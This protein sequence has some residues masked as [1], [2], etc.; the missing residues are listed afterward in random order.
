MSDYLLGEDLLGDDLGEDLMGDDLGAMRRRRRRSATLQWRR[1]QLAPGVSAPGARRLTLGMPPA[2]F[3]A[4]TAIN[5]IVAVQSNPQRPFRGER[6]IVNVL[7]SNGAGAVGIQIQDIRCG[8]ASQLAGVAGI[9]ADAFP[10]NA[11]DSTMVLDP[12]QPGVNFTIQY[13]NL[14]AVPTGESVV[15]QSTIVGQAVG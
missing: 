7:R 4:L 14:L 10:P 11:I 15:V 5:T 8:T 13:T 3:P 1:Q 12:I 9:S 2:A 6:L